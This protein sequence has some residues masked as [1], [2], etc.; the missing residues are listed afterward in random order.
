M[1]PIQWIIIGWSVMTVITYLIVMHDWEESD[2]GK[3]VLAEDYDVFSPEFRR[4]LIYIL[5]IPAI[6]ITWPYFI[7]KLIIEQIKYWIAVIAIK[8]IIYLSNKDG[9]DGMKNPN[10]LKKMLNIIK[11]LYN[12]DFKR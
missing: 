1:K 10:R 2:T 11:F 12:G 3:K 7:V 9:K 5:A 8:R 6:F 4:R